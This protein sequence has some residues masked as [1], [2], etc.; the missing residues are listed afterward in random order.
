MTNEGGGNDLGTIF[1]IGADGTDFEV[2]HSFG[3]GSGDGSRPCGHLTLV[4]STLY[5]ISSQGGTSGRGTVFRI[6]TD[7]TG[8]SVLHSFSGED[9]YCPAGSLTLSDSTL[10]GIARTNR[11]S[12]LVFQ[13]D[14][15]DGFSPL[16]SFASYRYGSP[17]S[18]LIVSGSA[19]YG[20]GRDDSSGGGGTIF[21]IIVPEPGSLALLVGAAVGWLTYACGRRSRSTRDTFSG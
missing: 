18:D 4:G 1:R 15:N 2:L 19:I 10:Y 7:G 20:T 17:A 8:F 11:G 16:Y 21:A 12:N 6:G 9:G 14:T 5:G 13:I 3:G